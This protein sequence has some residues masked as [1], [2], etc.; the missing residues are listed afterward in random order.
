MSK[1]ALPLLIVLFAIFQSCEKS[2][3]KNRIQSQNI[4]VEIGEKK[5]MVNEFIKRA[6][7]TPR[8]SYCRGDSYIHKKIVLNSLI[9][10]KLLALEFEKNNYSMTEAQKDIIKGQKEQGMRQEMLKVFGYETVEIDSAKIK[11]IANLSKRSYNIKFITIDK[12]YTKVINNIANDY[13]I[14]GLIKRLNLNTD[15]IKKSV[16]KSEEMI[17]AVHE[18]LFFRGPIKNKIYG[19]F[20]IDQKKIICF[21]IDSWITSVDVTQK[22]KEETWQEVENNY[23]EK[24]AIQNYAAY[25]KKIMKGKSLDYKADVFDDFSNKLRKIYLIEKEKKE[26]VINNEIWEINENT[27]I[28]SFEDIKKINDNILL[29]HDDKDYS[30]LDFLNLIKKHPLVFRNKKTNKKL[31]S[32]ELKYAIADLFRDVHITQ[33]AYGLDFDNHNS[34]IRIRNKWADYI[35][36]TVY[37]KKYLSSRGAQKERLSF[38]KVKVD[39]LQSIYSNVIKIDTDKFEK[40]NL[41]S[42]DMNVNFS[43]QPYAKVEPNFPVLTDDHLMDYGSKVIF[44]D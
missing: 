6:E 10:E 16:S 5:I 13:K 29:N 39:S 27:D 42:V 43:N 2:V 44:N 37:Q 32:N 18:V 12:K 11:K 30:V 28:V 25:V 15:L 41:S 8:P 7:Y 21:E 40:I 38:M 26:A 14:E 36:S 23:K 31:F 33:K 20:K 9:A 34:V 1:V 22:Q 3:E 4:L 17:E 35:K 24:N 19:P